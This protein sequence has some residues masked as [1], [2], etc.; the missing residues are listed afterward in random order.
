MR[1][2]GLRDATGAA[3]Q[4]A[5]SFAD[6]S[7]LAEH[8]AREEPSI[9]FFGV[10][11]DGSPALDAIRQSLAALARPAGFIAVTETMPPELLIEAMRAGVDEFL[12]PPLTDKTIRECVHNVGRK[13]GISGPG[14]SAGAGKIITVFSGKGGCGKTMLITSLAHQLTLMEQ[15]V[16][17]VDLNLQFGNVATFLDLQPRHT[18]M[19]C[20]ARD[21]KVD[22]EM[23]TRIPVRHA[24]GL[25]VIPGPEDPADSEQLKP[26]H[27]HALLDGLRRKFDFVIVD[28]L[29][30]FDEHNLT[31]LDI[32]DQIILLTDS[33][34]PSV[35]NTQRC[36]K[37]L[38]KLNYDQDKIMLVVNRVDRN[39]GASPKELQQ[40]FE[41]QVSVFIPNEFAT[42]MNSVDAG[43][44][45]TESAPK[46]G[47]VAAIRQLAK[48]L[49]DA[50]SQGRGSQS[51]LKKL[52]VR[53]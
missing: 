34:V 22:E 15:S 2:A 29:S 50:R 26:E 17:I 23:L 12:T 20:V 16:V 43:L 35:R 13:K 18:I 42:V 49:A 48:Q 3:G 21:G 44:P 6:A 9:V 14:P 53:R 41:Q 7:A 37:V 32:A 1:A 28:T 52:L 5:Q 45:L 10:G 36:L 4:E 25:A 31:A 30:I 19:D 39:V 47:V 46:S 38:A 33:L 51:W 8:L 11:C 27:T 24:S 40:A